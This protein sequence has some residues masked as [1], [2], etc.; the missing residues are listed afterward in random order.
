[1]ADDLARRSSP[2][3]TFRRWL[4]CS[5]RSANWLE[6]VAAGRGRRDVLINAPPRDAEDALERPCSFPPLRGWEASRVAVHVRELQ[7]GSRDRTQRRLP[8]AD[9]VGHATSRHGVTGFESRARTA[10][11]SESSTTPAEE[12]DSRRRSVGRSTGFGADV[13][14]VDDPPRRPMT[15]STPAELERTTDFCATDAFHPRLNDPQKSAK[16]RGR[17][18]LSHDDDLS[19]PPDPAVASTAR[20]P[21]RLVRP[22]PPLSV[23]RRPT[24]RTGRA[25]VSRPLECGGDRGAR[26]EARPV[27]ERS[28]ASAAP[29]PRRWRTVSPCGRV[30]L[31]PRPLDLRFDEIRQAWDTTYKSN[32]DSDYVC[33]VLVGSRGAKSTSYTRSMDG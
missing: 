18:A 11:R 15:P 20:L 31:R 32:S 33:G 5:T 10:R 30:L 3:S 4:A 8:Q 22:D 27:R 9:H 24:H 13:L 17:P 26:T 12:A 19:R 16:H 7:P 14:I 29:G 2:G 23:P 28:A 25:A 21:P 6:A 1:M